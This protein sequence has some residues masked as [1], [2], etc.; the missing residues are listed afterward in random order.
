MKK[1]IIAVL[2]LAM[3]LVM[4]CI[5]VY[6]GEVPDASADSKNIPKDGANKYNVAVVL[7]ASNSMNG[8]D[9]NGYR[10]EAISLFI[11]L[12]AS[13]GNHIGNVVF[14]NDILSTKDM[15]PADA[16]DVKTQ[17]V[18]D[19]RATKAT[20][21]T[22]IGKGID[23]AIT[24]LNTQ[25][26][27]SLPSVILF[28]SDGNTEMPDDSQQQESLNLKAEAIQKAREQGIQIYSVCLNANDYA[29]ISEMQQ[30]ADATGGQFNEVKTPEDLVG[31]FNNFYNMIYGTGTIAI[32]EEVVPE[33]G[34]VEKEFELPSFGVEEVNIIIYGAVSD[35]IITN[36]DGKVIDSTTINSGTYTMV[37]FS[38]VEKGQWKLTA[39]GNPGT[40]IKIN[41]VYNTDLTVKI[42]DSETR[43]GLNQD[44]T[45]HASL[46]AGNQ[47]ADQDEQ[48]AGYQ[49]KLQVLDAYRNIIEE[50]PM[51]VQDG[52]FVLA[53]A[54]EEGTY[55]YKVVVE[56]NYLTKESAE[57]G[58]VVVAEEN[59][60]Q[61]EDPVAENTPPVPVKNPVKKKIFI[62]PFK[63]AEYVLDLSTLAKD[64]EDTEL[65]YEIVSSS[66]IEGEDYTV[67]DNV[68]KVTQFSLV[69][70]AFTIRAY[71][72][73]GAYCDVEVIITS[74]NVG[75]VTLILLG[76]AAIVVVIVTYMGY[77]AATA[78]LF[79]G[80][81]YVK[82]GDDSG[83]KTD[84]I[85]TAR[86]GR[87][88]LSRFNI[89]EE[90][91]VYKRSYFQAEMGGKITLHSKK[92]LYYMNRKTKE[93]TIEGAEY[94]AP[95]YMVFMN[96]DNH[97]AYL[98]ISFM[99]NPGNRR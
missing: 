54:Y 22:N 79:N 90:W 43:Y 29:D 5:A 38:D 63:T 26:D 64:A 91:A 81:I 28:L 14:S 39:K 68:L 52:Q 8:T 4:Q 77:K 69:K 41:M 49:A 59:N 21:Y 70:G 84:K 96:S 71:D 23:Q 19:M 46:Q 87:V 80:S 88:M 50:I 86:R 57:F 61:E 65:H 15:V 44:V 55:Y 42:T 85:I 16:Q 89:P 45:I 51:K 83:D 40:Y 17:F 74:I 12:L 30:I 31:V 72:S 76:I 82:A 11:N 10:F 53:K 37:K 18:D 36:P 34:V 62:V 35:V 47:V 97:G 60:V 20:G 58:P 93:I 75:I 33:D 2:T 24:M 56:G 27:P 9:P 3:M 92:P 48:Y 95:E 99:T 98:K 1:R 67:Q 78:R 7:D 25:G 73:I 6:A 94:G 13:Q 66:F 32:D